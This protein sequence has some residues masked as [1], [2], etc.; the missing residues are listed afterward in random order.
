MSQANRK[1]Y[2]Q[3][4]ASVAGGKSGYQPAKKSRYSKSMRSDYGSHPFQ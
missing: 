1:K 4:A 2:D 3:M